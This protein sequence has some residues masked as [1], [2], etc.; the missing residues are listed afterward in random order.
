MKVSVTAVGFPLKADEHRNETNKNVVLQNLTC[1]LSSG[2]RNLIQDVSGQLYEQQKT[3]DPCQ[4]PSPWR[5][6]SIWRA[7]DLVSIHGLGPGNPP[8]DQASPDT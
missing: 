2:I 3:W 7:P 6:D 8:Q 1:R 5:R 4:P